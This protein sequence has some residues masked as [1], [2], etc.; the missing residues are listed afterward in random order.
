MFKLPNVITP[1]RGDDQ[2]DFLTSYSADDNT[3]LDCARSV[4]RVDL[5]IFSRWGDEIFT[6]SLT[7]EDAPIYW[8]GRNAAGKEVS[9]GT[10]FYLADVTFDT[11]DPVMQKQ[12]IKGWVYV[13]R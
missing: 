1:G 2:N 5:T 13:L 4:R 6:T 9:A 11:I 3:V 12:Q 7:D 8:D 10:Y